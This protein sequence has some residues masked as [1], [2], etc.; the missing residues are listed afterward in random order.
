MWYNSASFRM[1]FWIKLKI[2]SM[3][4][5]AAKNMENMKHSDLTQSQIDEDY[6]LIVPIFLEKYR[7]EKYSHTPEMDNVNLEP[8]TVM[9][10]QIF[11]HS[12]ELITTNIMVYSVEWHN[13]QGLGHVG[14]TCN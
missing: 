9:L 7:I 1:P 10:R 6:Q 4:L 12:T 13:R 14:N 11:H 5:L 2:L 3:D 8:F